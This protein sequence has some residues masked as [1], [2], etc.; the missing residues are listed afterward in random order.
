MK[1][2]ASFYRNL[3]DVQPLTV[4]IVKRVLCT[5]SLD[6]ASINKANV[7]AS[8]RRLNL[9]GFVLFVLGVEMRVDIICSSSFFSSQV[10]KTENKPHDRHMESNMSAPFLID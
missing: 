8:K 9:L 1:F 2:T 10:Q 7:A 3:G 5:T 6:P 4:T